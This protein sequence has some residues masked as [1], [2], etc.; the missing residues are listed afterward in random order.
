MTDSSGPGTETDGLADPTTLRRVQLIE[1]EILR[2]LARRCEEASLRWFVIGGTLLGAVRHRGFIP[3][4]DDIDVGMPRADYE[5]FEELCRRSSD[6]RFAW[7]SSSTD[8]AYPF[9]F[10]KLLR[11][12]THVIESAVAHLPIRHAI[13][14][15]VFPFDGAPGSAIGRRTH[16]MAFKV[17]ATALGARIR[18][19]GVRHYVAYLFRVV[20]RSWAVGLIGLLARRFAYDASSNVVNASGAWGYGRECQ[21]RSRFEPSAILEFEGMPVPAPGWWHAYLTQIYGD[22]M[23]LPPPEGRRPRHALTIVNLGDGAPTAAQAPS[24]PAPPVSTSHVRRTVVARLGIVVVRVGFALG[25]LRP[26]RARVV[27][28]AEDGARIGGNLLYIRRELER[29]TPPIPVRVVAYRMR[30]GFR[31]RIEGA[32][33]AF[34]A[35]YHLA[36]ARLFVVDEWFFPMYAITPRPGTVRVQV[37]HGAGAFKRFGY[38]VLDKSFGA[39]EEM[40]RLVPIHSNYDVCLVSSTTATVHYMDAFRLPR[41]RFTSALGLPRTDLFFDSEHRTR[42]TAAIR[43]RYTLPIDRRILLYAPTF[44]GDTP[45][46]AR[47][48]EGLDLMAL[49]DALAGEWV[50]LLRP[51]PFVHDPVRLTADLAG[52][53][54]DVSDWPDMNELM[55]VADL[56][57]TDY[58]S[59][60]FEFALLER[61]MAFFA[62]DYADY[63][64]ER[65]FYFDFLTGVPGPVFEKTHELAAYVKA[66][67]FD[68]GRVRAFAREWF[69]HADGHAS[70]RFVDRLVLPALRGEPLQLEAGPQPE[71]R[72]IGRPS[73]VSPRGSGLDGGSTR[74]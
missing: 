24:S 38:S 70:E 19:T 10:G 15:D 17:A 27:L 34:R 57:V 30:P 4:D 65:G 29:R 49:R 63:E 5:R 9:M 45:Q 1:L 20:P 44:R 39:D 25:R 2:E 31:G 56:L 13:Y 52:F 58:S 14:I 35:G 72:A 47:Y 54:I 68:L 36:V 64:H 69:D 51:H 18:R 42:A 41:D 43:R 12:D 61:P 67:D 66:A 59:A 46:A 21:P 74:S 37:W 32:W 26:L 73:P 48:R 11:A 50:L 60:I 7:Q 6:P 3:W 62:P 71:N 28:G 22:Y 23:R 40:V 16:G 55:L 33:Q 53:A 8:P